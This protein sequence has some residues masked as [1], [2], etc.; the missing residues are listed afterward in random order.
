MIY[1][2][3][4]ATTKVSNRAKKAMEPYLSEMYGNPSGIYELGRKARDA[5][6]KTRRMI[7]RAINAPAECI[8]FTSGGTE[9]DNWVLENGAYMGNH[10]VTSSI[11]HPAIL[12]KC[13][14]LED[15]GVDISYLEVDG[16]GI[17]HPEQIFAK[18]EKETSLISVMFANNEIGT[19][20]PIAEIGRIAHRNNI[21][22]HTDAVQ[23]FGHVPID[24][25]AMNIDMLSASSHKFNGPKGV[26]FL[27]VKNPEKMLSFIYGGTQEKGMR[28]GTE[29][30]PGIVGMG[31][32]AMEAISNMKDRM[33]KEVKLRNYTINRILH[34]IPQVKLNGHETKRLPGNVNFTI[35]GI[36]GN[37]LVRKM[38]Q[39]GIC[40]SAGSACSS[41]SA[42][43]SYVIKAL[44]IDDEQALG[45]VRITLCSD[46]TKEEMDYA[47]D[48][49]KENVKELRRKD[50]I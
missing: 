38:D 21:L 9:S 39:D 13:K 50:T 44:G 10:I 31:A 15:N 25:K 34:E 3:N 11:E 24:V 33:A 47:I 5:I 30:V 36:N 1:L 32:A 14:Q 43:P 35:R 19:I 12:N 48:K 22:F 2:D 26:G 37:D 16:K 7:A 28:A 8:F 20:E 27:Y 49:L 18:L 4:A 29:N 41:C 46:N 40:I 6:E 42:K 45:T 17:V 23:A